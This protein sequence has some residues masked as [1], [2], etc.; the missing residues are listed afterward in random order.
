MKSSHGRES[1]LRLTLFALSLLCLAAAPPAAKMYQ[2]DCMVFTPGFG[3]LKFSVKDLFES[4]PQFPFAYE[5]GDFQAKVLVK[6]GAPM[7]VEYRLGRDSSATLSINV[8]AKG[9]NLGRTLTLQLRPTGAE[10][11][12]LKFWL[13]DDFGSQPRLA[14]LSFKAENSAGADQPPDFEYFGMAHDKAVGSLGINVIY[15]RPD[16]VS[17]TQRQ[18]AAYSVFARNDFEHLRVEVRFTGRTPEGAPSCGL[19]YSD[20]LPGGIERGATRLG[21]W[22][23]K[24]FDGNVSTG[25]HKV[26]VS[27]WNG[28]VAGPDYAHDCGMQ[29]ILI[30]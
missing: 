17:T 29:R 21:E 16:L 26:C 27:A 28:E 7:A 11:G 1:K 23:G 15:F 13:P 22:D 4:G 30:Q 8:E 18:R 14:T 25:R 2:S 3:V 12:A 9:G 24:G 5:L 10:R 20:R 19:V 6:G